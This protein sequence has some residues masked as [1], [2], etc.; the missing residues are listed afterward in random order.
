MRKLLVIFLFAIVCTTHV[1][2]QNDADFPYNKMPDI[3]RGTKQLTLEGDLSVRMLDGAHKFIE[4][5]IDESVSNREKLWKRDLSSADAYDKSIDA[6]RRR[7][8]KIIGVVDKSVPLVSYN[9]GFPEKYTA[10]AMEKYATGSDNVVIAETANYKLYQVRWTVFNRVTGEGL[11]F[12]PKSKPSATI[13]AIPDADQEPEQLAGLAGGVAAESQLARNLASNGYQVLVPL[14]ISRDTVFAGQDKQQ[15]YREWL[16]RQSYHMGRHIIGYEVQKI[17]SAIDYFKL[18]D[19]Q[20]KIGVA[21]YNEGGLLAFYAAAVDKRIES[22]LVS[23]YFNS[24]QKVWDEPVY[25]NVWSLL[26]EFGDAEIATLIAPRSLTIE[27]SK[28]KLITDELSGNA[29]KGMQVE[30]LPYTGYKGKIE[31]PSFASV[32]S[33]YNRIDQLTKKDFLPKQL[34]VGKNG[35]AVIFFSKDAT[36]HF[37]RSLGNNQSLNLTNDQ[38]ADSRKNVDRKKRQLQQV[39][40]IEDD[41]QQMVRDSDQ[42]RDRFFLHKIMPEFPARNWST[43]PYHPYYPV[44]KFTDQ[45]DKYRK[46]FAEEIIGTFNDKLLP[47]NALTRKVYDK[48]RFTGYEVVMDVFPDLIATGILLIPKNIKSGERRPV[49]VTQHGRNDYPRKL[50]E[51]NATIYNNAAS[52]LADQGFIVYVPQNPYRGEDR[53]RWLAR[54][55]NNV[56]ATLFSFITAQHQQTINW[57]ASLEFVDK[58]RIAYYGLSYGGQTAMRVPPLLDGYCLS[59]CAGDFGDVTKKVADTH[60]KGSFMNTLEWEMP[61]FNMGNTFGYAEMAYLIF[62]RPFMVERGHHDLIQPD[63]WIGYEFGKIRFFYDQFN[64][65]DKA[66]I[67]YFNGGHTMRGEGTF[68]FL[69]KH[70][71]WP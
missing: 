33:E 48:E 44:S 11:L 60:Y 57:L 50:I 41:V 32:Q 40:E 42:E 31:T 54:K 70:L 65:G 4:R 34:I 45:S 24:R 69:H 2:A 10:P 13:I 63:S 66:E 27:Y 37:L 55:A 26:N 46:Y 3:F 19:P 7:F 8:A 23:G 58:S 52:K 43:Q 1:E 16:Y 12:E 61:Y 38:I 68:K 35:Q 67:E 22:V 59:I 21:G 30:G 5:K 71:N 17:M 53:Y 20:M 49:V 36:N 25:R 14:L 18:S 15:T 51:G 28:V 64:Q 29:Q 47:F 39:R 62:P 56:K 6:N 9:V